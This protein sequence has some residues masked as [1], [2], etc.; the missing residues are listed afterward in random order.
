[1]PCLQGKTFKAHAKQGEQPAQRKH[2][3]SHVGRSG[4]EL[5]ASEI[6]LCVEYVMLTDVGKPESYQKYM[7]IKTK[8][9]EGNARKVGFF[10]EEEMTSF[11]KKNTYQLA[12]LPIG[13]K[14]F[15]TRIFFH[16]YV[17]EL[18]L[19]DNIATPGQ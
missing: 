1:M 5:Q 9:R 17:Y 3:E 4:K 8:T 2:V 7:L 11:H 18:V 19:P 15:K 13:R 16:M 14:A 6:Y 10:N 12:K